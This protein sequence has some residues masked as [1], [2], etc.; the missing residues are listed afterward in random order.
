MM[1]AYL[2][3]LAA[4]ATGVVFAQSQHMAPDTL[5][6]TAA[7]QLA[8]SLEAARAHSRHVWRDTVPRNA[9]G[10]VNAYIEISRDDR[11]KWELDMRANARAI[12][13]MIPESVGGYPVNYGFVPQTVSYDGDPF[14]ALVLGPPIDGG[15]TV[16]GVVVGLMYMEDEKG[17]DSKV[18]LSAPTA[19]GRALHE[20][21]SADQQRI[22]E[23]FRRYKKHERGAYSK[24]PGWGSVGE[25]NALVTRTHDF[26]LNCREQS[27][28]PCTLSAFRGPVRR[29][30]HRP[31]T[32]H[33]T[34]PPPVVGDPTCHRM[35]EGCLDRCGYGRTVT[36]WIAH[37]PLPVGG[38]GAGGPHVTGLNGAGGD[39]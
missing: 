29:H 15:T 20:L 5:P 2:L 36:P 25:G 19:Y 11:R 21:A 12:D 22:A 23:Y 27:N 13:R 4:A 37:P 35:H 3:V 9:D 39:S 6:A 28:Q 17:M 1:P 34:N 7:A 32:A 18:V 24:V 26:F 30:R 10:T 14:D 8:Q 38:C 16:R 31:H 33:R